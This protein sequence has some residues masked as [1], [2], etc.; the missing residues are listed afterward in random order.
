MQNFKLRVARPTD[1]L[2]QVVKQ[3]TTGLDFKILSQFKDHEGFDG[4]II[5]NENS[6]YH[7]E[8]THHHR[9]VVGKAP[10]Q[11]NLIV[12][13]IS[14]KEDWQTQCLKM[15]EAGFELVK[16]YNP[17]WDINGKTFEDIDGYRVVLENSEWTK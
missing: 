3:Y 2:D 9:T 4:V 1:N 7:F 17:Y 10:T 14:S 8:F 6:I 5:G 11:D 16:S 12:F 15:I 13:Y